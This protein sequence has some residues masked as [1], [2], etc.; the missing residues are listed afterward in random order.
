MIEG[1]IKWLASR[2]GLLGGGRISSPEHCEINVYR[3][4]GEAGIQRRAREWARTEFGLVLLVAV[5]V[6]A[7]YKEC[8]LI[9]L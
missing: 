5:V 4:R 3:G 8:I 6:E 2:H 7:Q 9:D 1:L